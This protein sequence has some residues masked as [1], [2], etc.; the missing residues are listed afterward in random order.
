MDYEKDNPW[1]GKTY[2]AV[3]YCLKKAGAKGVRVDEIANYTKKT[4]RAIIF[5]FDRLTKI[6]WFCKWVEFN[7]TTRRYALYKEIR[8][9]PLS[10]LAFMVS[11]FFR[12]DEKA[13]VA[14]DGKTI[15]EREKK[16][17]DILMSSYDSF[18]KHIDEYLPE[19]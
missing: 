12:A 3:L 6:Q 8:K 7:P 19:N 5:E 2:L 1:Q 17:L 4:E 15:T 16:D 18:K 11:S 10:S 14:P 13:G 9:C